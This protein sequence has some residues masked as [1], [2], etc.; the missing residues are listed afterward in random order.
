MRTGPGFLPLFLIHPEPQP[1]S[2]WH[3]P[4]LDSLWR[5]ALQLSA[6]SLITC[7]PCGLA[8]QLVAAVILC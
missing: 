5:H 2:A 1:L 3:A 7:G 4:L 6:G 8:C